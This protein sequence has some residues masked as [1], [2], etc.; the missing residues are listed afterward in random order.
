[1]KSAS[2]ISRR[3]VRLLQLVAALAVPCVA[4]AAEERDIQFPDIP[5]YRTLKGDFHQHTTFS[6]GKV[7][8][9]VRVEESVQDG[10]D[11]MAVTDHLEWQPHRGDLPNPDRNRPFEIAR[12]AARLPAGLSEVDYWLIEQ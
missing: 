5:G 11:A 2:I 12:D 7:W 3:S 4:N 9:H 6:D 10:L 8:P 1:M